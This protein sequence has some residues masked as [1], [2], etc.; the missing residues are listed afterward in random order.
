MVI[1][2]FLP[3]FIDFVD[4]NFGR[5][6]NK[7]V[8]ITSEKYLFGLTPDHDVEFFHTDKDIFETLLTYMKTARKIILHGLWRDKIDQL[9]VQEPAL[10]DKSYWIMWG[11]D[12]YFPE[13]KTD[14]RKKVIKN[15]RYLVTKND[16]D[17]S[18]VRKLYGAS[19]IH[20]E[21]LNYTS[22]I[23]S[24]KKSF[25]PSYEGGRTN[26][27]L[28]NSATET[29]N[30]FESFELLK[31]LGT[32]NIHI[33]CPLSYGDPKYAE[34]VIV[35]G[36]KIFPGRFTPITEFMGIEQ[37]LNFI[38][39]IDIAVF[40]HKRQQAFGNLIYLL[41]F[42]K[43]VY[44]NKFSNLNLFF[45]KHGIK[46]FDIEFFDLEPLDVVVKTSNVKAVTDKFSE[47]TL[48]DDLKKIIC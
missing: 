31:D 20:I 2:K 42:G 34:E 48:I 43:K 16:F 28:G 14:F 25:F 37:Y 21:C 19:G 32:K 4:K 26:I 47:Q 17:V 45:N 36:T 3:P 15:V 5:G 18:L 7:Y 6:E 10:L 39:T 9:F 29:N 41:G 40:N 1:D 12:F 38:S 24:C 44:M 35:K 30:H 11:G 22:N 46:V 27:L 33:F 23:F 8:F 13:T